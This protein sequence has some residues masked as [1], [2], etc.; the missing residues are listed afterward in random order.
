LF[1][2]N[3]LR[4][5]DRNCF[6]NKDINKN[7]GIETR[8]WVLPFWKASDQE[9]NAIKIREPQGSKEVL[10]RQAL[11]IAFDLGYIYDELTQK[12]Y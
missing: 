12:N 3:N 10:L 5:G 1:G 2:I 6:G 9:F 4:N 8:I 7:A 11:S